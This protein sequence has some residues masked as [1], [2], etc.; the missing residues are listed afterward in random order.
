MKLMH[1]LLEGRKEDLRAK[2]IKSMDPEVLDWVL[3]ISDL[4]DFNHK[5]T[6]F[7]LRT[8]NKDSEDLDMDVDVLVGMVKDFDKYQ[9]Q[10]QKKDINQYKNAEELD[11]ALLPFKVKEKERELE[12]QTE[13][14]YEDDGFLVL[15]PLSVPAT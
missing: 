9:S 11:A 3:G 5:Y 7:V 13:K 4:K 8:L 6:D 14:I 15:R 10:L 2:Y 1:I 12:N